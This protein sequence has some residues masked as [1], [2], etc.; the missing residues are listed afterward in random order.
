MKIG[1]LKHLESFFQVNTIKGFKYL[2]RAGE[3]VNNYHS[4]DNKPPTF[5]MN[6]SGLV[7]KK[8]LNKISELKVTPNVIWLKF[9]NP[10]TLESIIHIFE[11]EFDYLITTLEIEVVERVGWRNYFTYEFESKAKQNSFFKKMNSVDGFT[12]SNLQLQS[13]SQDLFTN[14]N[15]KPLVKEN[16]KEETLSFPVLFDIDTYIKG[17]FTKEE[18]KAKILKFSDYLKGEFLGTVRSCLD[19]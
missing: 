7:I 8:P 17:T 10:S 9:D 13:E 3:I 12:L 16:S 14:L 5:E 15:I 11:K 1:Q 18:V 4:D 19:K 2:D 6:L